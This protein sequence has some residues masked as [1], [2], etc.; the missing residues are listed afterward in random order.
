MK[1]IAVFQLF[2]FKDEQVELPFTQIQKNFAAGY[3]L[4]V[5]PD[6]T[7]ENAGD[8]AERYLR[9][10]PFHLL[11]AMTGDTINRTNSQV[12]EPVKKHSFTCFLFMKKIEI[13]FL[14]TFQEK[15][16]RNQ[17]KPGMKLP[18]QPGKGIYHISQGIPEIPER[19]KFILFNI[20]YT[21]S[22][23]FIPHFKCEIILQ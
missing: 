4:D 16:F 9:E 3:I 23:C 1:R 21:I 18:A 5:H 13:A 2:P 19:N 11:P 17:G 7:D 15:R 8:M 12:L 20:P 6:I 14:F 10:N 22:E